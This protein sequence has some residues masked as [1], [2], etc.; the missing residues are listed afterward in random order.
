MLRNWNPPS[1]LVEMN[2][3]AAVTENS[4]AVPQ[5]LNIVLPYDPAI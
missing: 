5:K 2:Y 3:S 1:L 4:L